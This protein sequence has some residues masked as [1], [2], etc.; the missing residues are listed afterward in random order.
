VRRTQAKAVKSL[1]RTALGPLE[2]QVMRA[3]CSAGRAT[4][5]DIVVC[6]HERFAYT[7][8]MSTM[9]R[10]YHKGLL[11]RE[12]NLKAYVYHPAMTAPQLEAQIAHDLITTLLAFR[13]SS[14]GLLATE[15]VE[16]LWEYDAALLEEVEE[17]IRVRRCHH[18][19]YTSPASSPLSAVTYDWPLGIS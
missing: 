14:S 2:E 5:R 6:L 9:N 8:V 17:E 18:Q 12:T 4:V 19:G 16:A 11:H 1:V 3:M 15:L 7:T 13:K 10:L